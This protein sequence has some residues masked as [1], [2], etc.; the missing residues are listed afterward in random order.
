MEKSMSKYPDS[1]K[2]LVIGISGA[3]GVIMGIRTL[4]VLKSIKEIETHLVLSPAA[5]VAIKLETNWE[6]NDI[7]SLADFHYGYKDIGAAIA[8]GSFRRMG[9]LVV[10]CS[11]KTLSAIANA[12][13]NNLLIR[14][15]DVTLK[16]GKPLIL[17]VREAPFH[18]GH[19]R[20]MGM[21][22]DAGA[23]I[24]PT[25]P[26]F[27]PKPQTVDEIINNLVGRILKR[28]G[29]ENNQYTPWSGIDT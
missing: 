9:M 6:I 22:A 2:R 20:L 3:S 18:R 16:E 11:I 14:A 13:A 25:M 7:V 29:I 15:A 21:A 27:Y 1:T 28:I 8:S 10:P 26:A 5:E 4:E 12:F 24:F 19:I 23:V 17:A